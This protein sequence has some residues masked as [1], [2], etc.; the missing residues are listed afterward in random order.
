MMKNTVLIFVLFIICCKPIYSQTNISGIFTDTT[1]WDSTGNPYIANGNILVDTGGVLLIQPGVEIYFD[2]GKALQISGTM[3]AVGTDSF[4]IL[5]T[6]YDTVPGSWGVIH[7]TGSSKSAQFDSLENFIG[8]SILQYCHVSYGGGLGNIDAGIQMDTVS[9]FINKCKIFRNSGAGISAISDASPL[10]ID[11]NIFSENTEGGLDIVGNAKITKNIIEN[12]T[13]TGQG[14]AGLEVTGLSG[15]IHVID[16]I[17]RENFHIEDIY[18]TFYFSSGGLLI[19]SN[20]GLIIVDSNKIYNNKDSTCC[21]AAGG[22]K[23]IGNT[24]DIYIKNNLISNNNTIYNSGAGGIMIGSQSFGN[25]LHI[26]NNKILNNSAYG[27]FVDGQSNSTYGD[28]INIDSNIIDG[29]L[30]DGIYFYGA[31]YNVRN[32]L[33]INNLGNGISLRSAS[34]YFG[35]SSDISG[36]TIFRNKQYGITDGSGYGG[37]INNNLIAENDSGPFYLKTNKWTVNFNSIIGN[38]SNYYLTYIEKFPDNLDAKNNWWGTTDSSLIQSRI[39]DWHQD[40]SLGIVEFSPFLTDPPS[41]APISPPV[42]KSI[43][44][45]DSGFQVIWYLNRE[46]NLKGYKIY[47]DTNKTQFFDVGTDT[48]YFIS[49]SFINNDL[50]LVSYDSVADGNNDMLEGHESIPI[51]LM[52]QNNLPVI[53]S[54]AGTVATENILYNYQITITDL[55]TIDTLGYTLLVAPTNMTIDTN[56]GLISW[57]PLDGNVGNNSV[58][59]TVFDNYG[60][61]DTQSFVIN[62]QNV[63]NAPVITYLPSDTI[64]NQGSIYSDTVVASDEDVGDIV[65]FSLITPITGLSIGNL[66]GIISWIPGNQNIGLNIIVVEVTDDSGVTDTGNFTITVINTNDNPVITSSSI[67]NATEDISYVYNVTATDVDLLDTITYGLLINPTEMTINS[68]SGLIEW[69][70]DNNNVGNNDVSIIASDQ[71]GGV[72]TQT[73]VINVINVNDAPVITSTAPTWTPENELYTYDV[74]ATD[75]DVGDSIT[76][77]LI[78][79]PT[80]MTIDPL[81]G[82]IQWTPTSQDIRSHSIVVAVTDQLN[83]TDYQTYSLVVDPTVGIK[84]T[85]NITSNEFTGKLYDFIAYPRPAKRGID[86]INFKFVIELPSKAELFVYDLSGNLVVKKEQSYK[87]RQ[88]RLTEFEIGPWNLRNLNGRVVSFG[89]Y[90]AILKLTTDWDNQVN[91]RKIR[92]AISDR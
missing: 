62:V 67:T 32:N 44:R 74:E 65:R 26:I 69:T 90:I 83:L 92:I 46:L 33:I 15:E 38:G 80:S 58:S 81:T 85:T 16:N 82:L 55:D 75:V 71:N 24:K 8:G 72:D 12:N 56:N 10:I 23:I 3:Q 52:I 77:G 45:V 14:C 61:A 21:A 4:P 34:G 57:T 49:D 35:D 64:I 70:P 68:T 86:N 91:V 54:S 11:E 9:V 66:T 17:I 19:K 76:Y 39:Y 5:F 27:I 6:S 22:I 88:K 2:S 20:G 28:I 41:I 60:G 53:T 43:V 37:S 40:I 18:N 36:N 25:R 48:A 51:Q 78:L 89:G 87:L 7:F 79:N 63:L 73:F 84:S 30:K 29:H 47:Q 50:L 1:I 42:V 13:A 59:V 31:S